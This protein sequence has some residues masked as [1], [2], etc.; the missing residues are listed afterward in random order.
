MTEPHDPPAI[1]ALRTRITDD[2]AVTRRDFLRIL[3]TVSGG[4]FAGS[5]AIALGAFRRHASGDAAPIRIADGLK[6]GQ[7][8]Y[9]AFPAPDDQ[10]I[11]IRLADGSLVA[12]SAVCTHLACSVLW[13]PR[14]ERLD[15]PCHNGA[16]DAATGDVRFGPPPRPLPRIHIEDRSDGIWAT[17]V[18]PA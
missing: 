4:L 9:F 6:P 10:A 1:R 2:T 8:A 13:N 3:V 17:E 14:E 7:A 18:V 12:Y 5:V 11:A 15:C 16:F